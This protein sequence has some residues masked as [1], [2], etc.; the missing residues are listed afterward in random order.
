MVAG[1]SMVVAVSIPVV[2]EF[3][4]DWFELQAAA[5]RVNASAKKP[6]LNV[7]FIIVSIRFVI[8]LYHWRAK[9]NLELSGRNKKIFFLSLGYNSN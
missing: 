7:F 8:L 3:S 6:N 4:P 5:S 2:S 9:G 1:V